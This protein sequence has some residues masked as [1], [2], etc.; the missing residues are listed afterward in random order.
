MI[1]P[2]KSA[3]SKE[4]HRLLFPKPAG[5]AIQDGIRPILKVVLALMQLPT[6]LRALRLAKE[7]VHHEII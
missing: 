2:P 4:L 1:I 5:F 7:A 6:A 3:S